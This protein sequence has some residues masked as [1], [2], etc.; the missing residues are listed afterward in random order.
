M[1]GR[2]SL[3]STP[4]L[5]RTAAVLL[6]LLVMALAWVWI[7][8]PLAAAHR[9]ANLRI[10]EAREQLMRLEHLAAERTTLEARAAA[11]AAQPDVM[12]YYLT[13]DTDAVAAAAL[14]AKITALV[15][16]NG[17][18]LGSI[19]PMPG[20]E[21]HGLRRIAVRIQMT[22][23]IN[24]L[25]STLHSLET[26]LP[27]LF[28]SDLDIQSQLPPSAAAMALQSEPLLIITAEVSGY[29]ASTAGVDIP[30]SNP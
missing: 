17:G 21:D 13:G 1:T 4:W 18:S 26:E 16:G 24:A 25:L 30:R 6:L 20:A 12:A 11:L 2:S 19:Q 15:N 10:D 29:L 9:D 28:V 14:Q 7:A 8:E 3:F 22:A 27:L 5:S 23:P